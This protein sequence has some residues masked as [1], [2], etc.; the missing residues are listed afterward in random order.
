MKQQSHWKI[1]FE[2]KI[3]A[4]INTLGHSCLIAV[5]PIFINAVNSTKNDHGSH[6][7]RVAERSLVAE[8]RACKNKLPAAVGARDENEKRSFFDSAT[9]NALAKCERRMA[10][11]VRRGNGRRCVLLTT[12][13]VIHRRT[14]L[15]VA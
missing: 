9:R 6:G 12:T 8:Q 1:R 4:A 5:L 11:H 14:A 13:A 7:E 15:H 10:M 3:P 2:W